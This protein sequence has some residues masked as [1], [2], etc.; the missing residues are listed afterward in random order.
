M[1]LLFTSA[2][3]PAPS[4]P[5]LYI[6]D[7][8]SG[9]N[10][11]V[12]GIDGWDDDFIQSQSLTYGPMTFEDVETGL[13]ATNETGGYWCRRLSRVLLKATFSNSGANAVVWPIYYDANGVENIG[14][15]VT[16]TA[17]TRTEGAGVY[18]APMEFF[19]TNG[20][21]QMRFYVVSV[22]AGTLNLSMA[23]V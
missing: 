10:I 3:D 2:N 8:E 4:L 23:G 15:A 7:A 6:R 14:D 20:A 5:D 12:A 16:I 9:S 1:L 17:T 13:I 11:P 19:E 18:M 22:S 21:N